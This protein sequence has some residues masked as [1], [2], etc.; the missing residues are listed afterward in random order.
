ML[1]TTLVKVNGSNLK[2]TGDNI[3]CGVHDVA[4]SVL[5]HTE[6]FQK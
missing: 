1:N 4:I 3:F 2:K 5:G 6:A